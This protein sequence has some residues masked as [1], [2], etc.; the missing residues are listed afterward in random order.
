MNSDAD[1]MAKTVAGDAEAFGL[2]VNRH[3]ER[4]KAFLYRLSGDREEAKDC[5]Q[6]V[7][8][9]VWRARATYQPQ[10]KFTTFLYT[11]ARNCWRDGQRRRATQPPIT[12]LEEQLGPAG[13]RMLQWMVESAE[14]AEETVLRRYETYK[15]RRAIAELPEGQ[16][17]VFILAHLEEL[18]YA[19]I[20]EILG[21]PTGT[22][23]SRMHYAVQRLREWLVEER[24]PD[25]G[26]EV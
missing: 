24:P 19:E 8:L 17:T 6:E 22:V 11:V 20:A 15:I 3:R 26:N 23:K 10:M 25:A 7:W 4:I 12:P 13:R 5:A 18:P 2:V 9:R 1:L 14:T 16:R 21:I